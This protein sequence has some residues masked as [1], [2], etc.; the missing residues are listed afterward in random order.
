[1]G[2]SRAGREGAL[3]CHC[4]A[5]SICGPAHTRWRS[6]ALS[7]PPASLHPVFS[8][9]VVAR[10][11]KV[12][13]GAGRLSLG[14]KPSYFEDLRWGITLSFVCFKTFNMCWL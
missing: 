12:D 8:A 13:G 9:G 2:D 14:L 5:L 10:V 1:M 4:R 11:L 7:C 3:P 6:L